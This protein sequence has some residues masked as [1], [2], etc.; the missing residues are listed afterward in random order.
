MQLVAHKFTEVGTVQRYRYWIIMAVVVFLGGYAYSYVQNAG[1]Q[2]VR[3][4]QSE[5]VRLNERALITMQ[6]ILSDGRPAGLEHMEPGLELVG[7]SYDELIGANPTW[8]ILRFNADELV[9]E[10]TCLTHT[11]GYL[12]ERDGLV[13]VFDGLPGPCSVLREL[14]QIPVSK[15]PADTRLVLQQGKLTFT[16]DN[17]MQ[18]LL[19]GLVGDG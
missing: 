6:Y 2:P 15:M 9:V 17:Q 4:D 16:D 19:D 13:A 7:A 14:T 11:G 18:E 10:V 8:S 12:G 1:P 3:G 5:L